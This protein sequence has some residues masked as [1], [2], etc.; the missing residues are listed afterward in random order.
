M[1][2]AMRDGAKSGYLKYFLLGMLVMAA[3]GLVLT[4][5]GGF[6]RGG[7]STN[8]VA[9]GDGIEISTVE[10]D[11]SVR[12][13]LARQGM[14]SQEAYQMGLIYQI[15]NGEIQTRILSREARKLG[16]NV[17]DDTVKKQIS[18]LAEPLAT[19]GVSK[20]DAL[21]QILRSQG[22]SEGEFIQAIRQE[23]GNTLFRNAILSGASRISKEQAMDLYMF[24]HESRDF[25]GF[26]LSNKTAKATEE[27]TEEN[28]QKYYD[29][30]KSDFA[31]PETRDITIATLKRENLEGLVEITDKEL[32]KIYKDEIDSFKNPEKRKLRQA[33][34]STQADAQDVFNK[35]EKGKSLK[36]AVKEVTGK[37]SSYLSEGAFEQ[38]GLL[39]EISEP[40]FDAKQGDLL[41]PIQTALGWHVMELV[42]IVK[43]ETE[44][45]ESVKKE[46]RDSVLQERMMDS[47]ISAANTLDDRLAAGDELETVA[48]D[49][50]LTTEKL[51]KFNQ[52]GFNDKNKDLFSVFEGDK[53]QILEAAFE[54][55]VGESSPVMELDD[56]R[57][58]TVR[59]DNVTPLRHKS[60][61]DVKASLKKRWMGEQKRLANRAR[62]EEAFAKLKNGGTLADVAKEYGVSLSNYKG[63]S[64]SKEPKSP[65]TFP[66]VRQIF[67][68][69]KDSAL[70]LDTASG[71]I[72]GEVTAI[73]LP[74][75]KQ[76]EKEADEIINATAEILPQEI[77]S[78]Y[79]NSLS[80]RYKVKVNNRVLEAV[81]GVS[82]AGN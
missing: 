31:I 61:E 1:L 41:G 46:L 82:P 74:D 28:L 79:V 9:K 60:Y 11:R 62:A 5:V 8:L 63:V 59:V 48:E 78:Q 6:W 14:S 47:L 70:K 57:F 17:S 49:M 13:I 58:V 19:G 40:V 69:D 80:Q 51:T 16:I 39:D 15:L 37:D 30:N 10:F 44:S 81:Y 45:F 35:V 34:L 71:Y 20:S 26:M 55:D 3:G 73:N 77:L 18:K 22:I 68:A 7:I 65:L 53:A 38:N 67:D 36:D 66:N 54:F 4:D 23:M 50:G 72:I 52:G 76:A 2:R 21:K 33:I 43:P 29:A 64:R 25:R 32:K 56:G 27:P 24:R 75:S 42:E 12:R